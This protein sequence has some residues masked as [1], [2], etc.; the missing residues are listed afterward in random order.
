MT[1][2]KHGVERQDVSEE[3][4]R[5]LIEKVIR[6]AKVRNAIETLSTEIPR[7]TEAIHYL[8]ARKEAAAK[9][10]DKTKSAITGIR[11][12]VMTSKSELIPLQKKK[13][14][15]AE[16]YAKLETAEKDVEEKRAAL[17]KVRAEIRKMREEVSRS[18][19]TFSSLERAHKEVMNRKEKIEEECSSLKAKLSDLELEASVMNGTF[20][21]IIGVQPEGFDFD[22]FEGIQEDLE[23]K[24]ADFTNEMNEEIE[25]VQ[26]DTASLKRQLAESQ[27]AE[28]SLL[29][30]DERFQEVVDGLKS[31]IGEYGDLESVKA[32]TAELAN[33][34]KWLT[35]SCKETEQATDRL[36]SALKSL[37]ERLANENEAKRKSTKRHSY[38]I[39]RKKEMDGFTDPEDAVRRMREETRSLEMDSK[40]EKG[41]LEMIGLLNREADPVIDK[42]GSSLEAYNGLIAGFEQKINALLSP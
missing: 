29:S 25:K 20:S 28:K 4:V 21:L 24:V 17:P 31:Q 40:T 3:W 34:E 33:Q 9:R 23:K 5:D 30:K 32:E 36:E 41:M 19:Q 38:L 6:Q 26:K 10:L 14:A 35:S 15:I 42:L 1:M 22:T 27:E 12:R 11:E 18:F 2:A 16:E 8:E 13:E 39:E 37:E 7:D